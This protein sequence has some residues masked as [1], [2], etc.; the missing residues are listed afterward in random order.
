MLR[1]TSKIT[2]S[3]V[4]LRDELQ[5][6]GF[7]L[8]DQQTNPVY[9]EVGMNKTEYDYIVS[10]HLYEANAQ[11]A[12]AKKKAIAPPVGSF[13]I[14]AAW[15]VLTT[16]EASSGRFFT[17]QAFVVPPGGAGSVQTV[18]LVGLHVF[19]GGGSASGN[20]AGLWATF[21]QTDNAPLAGTRNGWT[22]SG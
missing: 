12:Y 8:F 9:Y 11:A 16:A 19:A 15:K 1:H 4:A 10:N 13:E 5:V 22:I 17:S 6:D 2:S 3:D 7:A 14:K 20:S 18:G 21:Y